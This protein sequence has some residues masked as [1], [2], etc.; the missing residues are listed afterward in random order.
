VHAAGQ[1]QREQALGV[2]E[3]RTTI[4]DSRSDQPGAVALESSAARLVG[5][6]HRHRA[7]GTPSYRPSDQ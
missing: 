6:A 2:A 4:V 1:R 3:T 5:A 7:G